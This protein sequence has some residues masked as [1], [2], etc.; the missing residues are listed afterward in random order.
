MKL[1]SQVLSLG[2]AAAVLSAG[3]GAI[4]LVASARLGHSI[5][6]VLQSGQALQLSQVAD[7]MHDAIRGDAQ[8]A[9]LG[10]LEKNPDRILEV[11][12]DLKEHTDNLTQSLSRLQATT[13]SRASTDALALVQ[14]VTP[15]VPGGCAQPALQAAKV[16]AASP[17]ST[18]MPEFLAA[19]GELETQMANLS[20]SIEKNGETISTQAMG[21]VDQTRLMI[22]L[23]L[24]L[25]TASLVVGSLALARRMTQPME[26][27]VDLSERIA[28][29]DLSSEIHACWQR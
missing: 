6:A 4:G 1:R 16:D 23:A 7:M 17:P 15:P 8:Q 28:Q 11:E 3:V 20:E 26:A 10:A 9:L 19:F 22:G 12:K 14:P 21:G 27:A 5:D 25:A 13:L 24:V 29:G 2:L 18:Q